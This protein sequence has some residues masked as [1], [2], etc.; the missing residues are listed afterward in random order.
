VDRHPPAP[1][2]QIEN[3]LFRDDADSVT[4]NN[5]P[6]TT[7]W[8]AGG[9]A[10]AGSRAERTTRQD[11]TFLVAERPM[12]AAVARKSQGAAGHRRRVWFGRAQRM[13][14]ESDTGTP[15]TARERGNPGLERLGVAAHVTLVWASQ[16]KADPCSWPQCAAAVPDGFGGS[17]RPVHAWRAVAALPCDE[18]KTTLPYTATSILFQKIGEL[19]Q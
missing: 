1:F 10:A 4:K 15:H 7:R 6:G 11:P 19:Y 2:G 12:Q 17:P 3:N 13:G 8:P 18:V 16:S 9:P 5:R 14:D